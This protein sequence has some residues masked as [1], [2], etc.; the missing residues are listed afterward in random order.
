MAQRKSIRGSRSSVLWLVIIL[1]LVLAIALAAVVFVIGPEQELAIQATATAQA[2][3][4]EV[5]RAYDAGVAFATAGDWEKAA[6]EFARVIAME[7]AYKDA[8]ARLAETRTKVEAAK[9][10]ATTQAIAMARQVAATATAEA[11]V[12]AEQAQVEAH[13]TATVQAQATAEA[14]ANDR[15]T[16]VAAPTATAEALEVRY[17]KGL[18][19]INM[20]RW[21]EAKAELEQVFE[22]D[23]GYK[24]VQAR[25]VDVEARLADIRALT[26]TATLVPTNTPTPATTATTATSTP[27]PENIVTNGDFEVP[28]VGALWATYDAGQTFGGWMVESGSI[29]H[30]GGDWQAVTGYESVDLSGNEA[31]AVY[32]DLPTTSGQTYLLRFAMAGNPYGGSAVKRMQIWWDTTLIDSLFF[33]TTGHSGQSMGWEYHEYSVVATG[34]VTR[35]TFKGMTDEQ[36]GPALDDVTVR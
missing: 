18:G 30:V 2:H 17:Q 5:Q 15:A 6:E 13:A 28:N 9:A 34:N 25:L 26:S 19:Y 32:Q 8:A 36:W 11:I 12:Q 31:G 16:A 24:D 27:T 35:L 7:P 23:P 1:V 21:D 33:D 4:S 10:A 14:Q 22:V 3:A 20:G 29:D